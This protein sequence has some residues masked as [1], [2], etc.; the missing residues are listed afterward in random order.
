MHT[1]FIKSKDME[2]N[3]FQQRQPVMNT[4]NKNMTLSINHFITYNNAFLIVL[5]SV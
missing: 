5:F 3:S 4:N 2:Y 1:F